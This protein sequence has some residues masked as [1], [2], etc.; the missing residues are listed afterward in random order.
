MER[1]IINISS[2]IIMIITIIASFLLLGSLAVM[3]E[4]WK[5]SA[6]PLIVSIICSVWLGGIGT[7]IYII[8][9]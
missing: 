7:L 4:A 9:K 2:Y 3:V 1:K 8:N 6:V 5:I